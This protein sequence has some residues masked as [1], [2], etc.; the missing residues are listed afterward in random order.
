MHISAQ[1]CKNGYVDYPQALTLHSRH[2]RQG[3]QSFPSQQAALKNKRTSEQEELILE[4]PGAQQLTYS[5]GSDAYK[6]LEPN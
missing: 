5:K 3:L 6:H 2:R 1:Q 4:E